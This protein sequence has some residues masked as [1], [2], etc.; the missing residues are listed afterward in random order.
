MSRAH[1]AAR[2]SRWAGVTVGARGCRKCTPSRCS[3]WYAAKWLPS[4][5]AP[6]RPPTRGLPRTAT[7]MSPVRLEHDARMMKPSLP[8]AAR[9]A[10]E[11]MDRAPAEPPTV[12]VTAT[13]EELLGEPPTRASHERVKLCTRGERS[14][15]G[16]AASVKA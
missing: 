10:S 4:Q 2:S 13:A 7:V 8:V 14:R 6:P 16:S 5:G 9:A 1:S 3:R 12:I 11:M 15:E